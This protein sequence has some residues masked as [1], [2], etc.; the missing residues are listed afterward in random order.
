MS[1]KT[2]TA[3]APVAGVVM[4]NLYTRPSGRRR[5]AGK[6]GV[7]VASVAVFLTLWQWV[8]GQ[9]NPILLATPTAVVA[10]FFDLL[11]K[12]ELQPA[13][14]LAMGDLVIGFGLAIIVGVTIGFLVGR[15][16]TIEQIFNPYIN[17]MQATPLIALV[18]LVVVWFGIGIEARVAVV[19]VLSVWS[20]IINTATGVKGTPV[21]LIEV[22]RIYHLNGIE[23]LRWIAFPFAVPFIFSGLR[24]GLGKALI[25]MVI[26]EM[27][28][29]VVGLGGLLLDYGAQFKTA[30]L[31]AAI[32]TAS[33]VGVI[34]AVALDFT[35]ARFFPWVQATSTRREV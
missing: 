27:Q 28:V 15:F 26:A 8:G 3:V 2:A 5:A 4:S 33:L 9:M 20:I 29:T 1:D 24:I 14:L 17:F 22:G 21:A 31:L 25:G 32:V 30:Y 19:F 11:Q 10:A 12:N 6:L 34:T 16:R 18:P 35:V 7:Q 23:Q 13:F